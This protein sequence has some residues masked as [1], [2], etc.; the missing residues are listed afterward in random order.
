MLL[1]L[2]TCSSRLQIHR[3]LASHVPLSSSLPKSPFP[4]CCKQCCVA[5]RLPASGEQQLSFC[6]SGH[7]LIREGLPCCSLGYLYPSVEH[8]DGIVPVRPPSASNRFQLVPVS[9]HKA[10]RCSTA[11]E[12]HRQ[13]Q[14]PHLP[15]STA[16]FSTKLHVYCRCRVKD[17]R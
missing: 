8:R 14:H 15:G 11:S 17:R 3:L 12:T 5:H 9:Q 10:L 16:I 6:H 1:C 4:P 13:K 7:G 2:Y